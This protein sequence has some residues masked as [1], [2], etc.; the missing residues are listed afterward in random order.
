MFATLQTDYRQI[1][2][3]LQAQFGE[4][5]YKLRTV[6]FWLTEVRI[7]R[8]DVHDELRT[9]RS[10]CDGLNAKILAILNKYLFESALSIAETLPVG[11]STVLLHLHDSLGFRSFHLYWMPQRPMPDLSEK[12]KK[13]AKVKLP[14]L[15][16]AERAGWDY[17]IT[18]GRLDIQDQKLCA[19]S[20][21][22]RA[23]SMLST[24]SQIMPK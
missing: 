20:C 9:G 7:G 14:F 1:T 12:R 23:T 6:Q 21:R 2:D 10:L 24:N 13:D 16:I 15:H 8:Q 17:V 11:Y 5:A 3:R 19:R 18:K 22:N 4:Y